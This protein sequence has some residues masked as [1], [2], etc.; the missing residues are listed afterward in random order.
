MMRSKT[1]AKEA[2][3]IYNNGKMF[4]YD[5]ATRFKVNLI[6]RGTDTRINIQFNT[7]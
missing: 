2:L 1:L 7:Q 4:A 5:H 3:M 6:N